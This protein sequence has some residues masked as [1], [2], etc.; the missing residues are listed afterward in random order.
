MSRLSR[1]APCCA[2]APPSERLVREG[3]HASR[4]IHGHPMGAVV[5]AGDE[6]VAA[7][8]FGS[9]SLRS[10]ASTRVPFFAYAFT[11]TGFEDR[12]LL[13]LLALDP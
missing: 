6:D 7:V 13:P 5:W 9:G 1:V 8:P 11:W 3:L 4:G 12:L 2:M 10:G